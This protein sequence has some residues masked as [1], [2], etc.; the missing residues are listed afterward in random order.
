M[1]GVK[2]Y[3]FRCCTWCVCFFLSFREGLIAKYD[4]LFGGESSGNEFSEQ[5]QFGKRWGWYSSLYAL[6]KGDIRRFD[7]IT[8]LPV[9]QSLTFLTFEKQKTEIEM[10]MINK[11]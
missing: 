7:E 6:A 9:H 5:A 2:R 1:R 4:D 3:A 8:K 11:K 10:K